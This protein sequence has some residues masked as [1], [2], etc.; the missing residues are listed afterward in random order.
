[1]SALIKRSEANVTNLFVPIKAVGFHNIRCR[2]DLASCEFLGS[3]LRGRHGWQRSSAFLRHFSGQSVW[4]ILLA[5]SVRSCNKCWPWLAHQWSCWGTGSLEVWEIK[6][7]PSCIHFLE[8]YLQYWLL[9]QNMF[10]EVL[11]IQSY[12]LLVLFSSCFVEKSWRILCFLS[13]SEHLCFQIG[14]SLK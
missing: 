12:T 7:N 8:N 11:L 6:R 1:M 14:R 9:N 13:P 3:T 2:S 4:V 10:L 5:D